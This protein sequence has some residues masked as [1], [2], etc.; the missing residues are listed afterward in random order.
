[1][2]PE[3]TVRR[4]YEAYQARDWQSAESMMHPDVMLKMPATRERLAGRVQVIGFQRDYPEPWGDLAVLQVVGGADTTVAEVEVQAPG[5]IFRMVAFWQFRD[6]LLWRGT[7]Y[8]VTVGEE[9]PSDRA[10]F[11]VDDLATSD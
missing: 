5:S 9:P 10:H 3:Q 8:W 4:V 11:I 7:E 1:M 6:G 2:S